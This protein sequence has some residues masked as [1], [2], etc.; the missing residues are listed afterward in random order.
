[1]RLLFVEDDVNFSEQLSAILKQYYAVDIAND[2]ETAWEWLQLVNYDAIV[3]DV[4]LPKLNGIELCQRVRTSGQQIPILLLTGQSTIDDRIIGL[5]AGADD[6]LIKPVG[7]QEVLARLRALLRRPPAIAPTRLEW[8]SLQI[9][10]ERHQATFDGTTI[11]LT[12]KEYLL[13]KLFLRRSDWVHKHSAILEQLWNLDCDLPSEQAV[14]AHV[15]GLRRK[16]K[17]VGAADLIETVYGVGYRLNP[18]YAEPIRSHHHT[19]TVL[20]VT[21]Q[22]QNAEEMKELLEPCGVSIAVS[23]DPSALLKTLDLTQPNLLLLAADAI[24]LDRLT[25]CQI[26]RR[27]R[28]WNWLPIVLMMTTTEPDG[29]NQG[30]AAGADDFVHDPVIPSELTNRVLN[31]LERV[32]QLQKRFQTV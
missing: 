2:G 26:V 31:R 5:D 28:R 23:I 9:D 30:F 24:G 10:P 11:A 27:D 20:I 22:T 1:M 14:R 6:Y 8:G 32:R 21:N 15:K 29:I 4:M 25:L 18:R 17:A 16:L 7:F 12:L 13:L 19:A 3:L